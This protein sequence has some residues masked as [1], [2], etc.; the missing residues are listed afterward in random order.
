MRIEITGYL[1]F[2]KLLGKRY[3]E[4]SDGSTL[5]MLLEKMADEIGKDFAGTIYNVQTGLMPNIVIL[6]NGRHLRH[7]PDGFDNPLT[8]GDSVA[9]FPPIL[10]G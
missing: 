10:G 3:V 1:S 6:V 9:V 4:I 7:L 5:K 2:G 8:E